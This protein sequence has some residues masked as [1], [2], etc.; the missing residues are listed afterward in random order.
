MAAKTPPSPDGLSVRGA[1]LTSA[2]LSPKAALG[3]VGILAA[4]LGF[5]IV[6]V[7]Q[8]KPKASPQELE[9]TELQPALGAAK[10]LTMDVPDIAD[11]SKPVA[12]PELPAR[13]TL[14]PPITRS[15]QRAAKPSGTSSEELARMAGTEIATFASSEISQSVPSAGSSANVSS[16]GQPSRAALNAVS[17]LAAEGD[18]ANEPD[19][20]RQLEKLA[21]LKERRESAYLERQ[22]AAPRS[23]F[24]IKTGTVIPGVLLTGLNSDLPGEIVAQVAQNVYDTA[25]GNHL[26]IPQGTKLFGHYDSKVAFGQAR[27]LVS[28]QRLVFP[29]ASTLELDGMGGYDRGGNAGF[30]GKVNNHYGRL[31]GFALL[32]SA[33][34]AGYQI[35]QPDR[36]STLAP[37][38]EQQIAAAAVGQQMAQLGTEIARRNMRV[39]PT[40]T[41]EK[42]YRLH[43][44]VNKDIAFPGS[45][46][47]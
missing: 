43:V 37:L 27:L 13:S 42:G 5:I 34:S 45:Y 8:E 28:W 14:P 1:P 16:L 4:M 36:N 46:R 38:S 33:I 3:A 47:P 18:P 24:E 6:N 40:I 11:T 25:S 23:P 9:A 17:A 35:S 21:F 44:M 29:D 26:L 32:T 20:N 2:R 31:F 15:E 30:A 22:L 41:V 19:L 10:T 39:Q 12:V 7:S